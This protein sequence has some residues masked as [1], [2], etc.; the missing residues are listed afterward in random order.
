MDTTI[1]ESLWNKIISTFGE[2]R[3]DL[4][5]DASLQAY[6]SSNYDTAK[7][8]S[9]TALDIYQKLGTTVD[10]QKVLSVY[11]GIT[12]SLLDLDRYKEA[13][14][15]LVEAG[16][17][18]RN[19]DEGEYMASMWR[20]IDSFINAGSFSLALSTS[21]KL[22]ADPLLVIEDEQYLQLYSWVA[23][24]YQ[25]LGT[26]DFAICYLESAR[27]MADTLQRPRRCAWIHDSLANCFIQTGEATKALHYARLSL[28]YAIVKNDSNLLSYAHWSMGRA[29]FLVGEFNLARSHFNRCKELLQQRSGLELKWSLQIESYLA[30]IFEKEGKA[31]ECEVI[32]ARVR[33]LTKEHEVVGK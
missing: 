17:F 30:D 13:A 3:A 28:D 33:S 29:R 6:Q 9:E 22:L 8:L 2:E 12:C 15:L 26:F 11:A 31:H 23:E 7:L 1:S 4:C 18:A 32:R 19:F 27:K 21:L 24:I 14:D 25:E 16:S 10:Y 5:L 20:A